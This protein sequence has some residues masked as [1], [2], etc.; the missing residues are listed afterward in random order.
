MEKL[1]FLVFSYYREDPQIKKLLEPIHWCS[2]TRDWDS[3]HI[4]CLNLQHY[5]EV[6]ELLAF[7]E[8]PFALLGIAKKII[9]TAPGSIQNTF[10][11][12]LRSNIDLLN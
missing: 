3:I 7:L 5:G 10:T 6:V 2:F 1:K 9:L 8:P 11:I 12:R 4:E